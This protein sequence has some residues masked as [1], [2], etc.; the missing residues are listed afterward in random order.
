MLSD[1]QFWVAIAFV[2]FVLAIFNPIRKILSSSLDT[3][4]KEIRDSID[5]A[6]KIKNDAQLT[7]GDIKNPLIFEP[8]K[9]SLINWS[10][11][12]ISNNI[13]DIDKIK[14]MPDSFGSFK[15]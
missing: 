10:E 12:L 2:V 5:Q 7:L 1:P 15:A 6:E 4:I 8:L 13:R 11:I 14:S 9:I 3:K